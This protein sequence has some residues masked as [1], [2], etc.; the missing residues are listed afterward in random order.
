MTE[1]PNQVK[2]GTRAL[3]LWSFGDSSLSK[4]YGSGDPEF[5]VLQR[6]DQQFLVSPPKGTASMP[7]RVKVD[8]NISLVWRRKGMTKLNLE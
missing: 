4:K 6:P 2:Y 5:I 3:E 8:G 7:Q 1:N